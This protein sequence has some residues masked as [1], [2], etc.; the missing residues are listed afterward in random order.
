MAGYVSSVTVITYGITSVMLDVANMYL[1]F[2][3]G[4][5]KFIISVI[6]PLIRMNILAFSRYFVRKAYP[7]EFLKE[8]L[9][10]SFLTITSMPDIPEYQSVYIIF[11]K[12]SFN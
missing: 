10:N 4:K 3:S 5:I 7:C 6:S 1:G 8:P 9:I 11:Y 2:C 12:C